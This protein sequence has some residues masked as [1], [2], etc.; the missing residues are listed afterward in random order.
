MQEAIANS[1]VDVVDGI[2]LVARLHVDSSTDKTNFKA[3]MKALKELPMGSDALD[4]AYDQALQRIEDQK[5]GFC[6]LAK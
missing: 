6:D 3:I 2:F 1:I 4:L 5:L